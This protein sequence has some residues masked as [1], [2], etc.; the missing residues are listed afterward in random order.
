MPY[1]NPADKAAWLR[2]NRPSRATGALGDFPLQ[3]DGKARWR[4]YRKPPAPCGTD[5]GYRRHRDNG[6]DACDP[7]KAAHAFDTHARRMRS[8]RATDTF[9]L[10]WRAA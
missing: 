6:E 7:C 4:P 10:T 1:A 9:R 8:R 3:P 2:A 5:G